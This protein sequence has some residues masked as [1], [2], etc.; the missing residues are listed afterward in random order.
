MNPTPKHIAFKI[1]RALS[2]SP[3]LG[4]P[5]ALFISVFFFDDPN[6]IA[7]ELIIALIFIY[8]YPLILIANMKLSHSLYDKKKT[9]A[10][11]VLLWPIVLFAYLILEVL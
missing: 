1:L 4:W 5:L 9:L 8:T 3:I 10:Y 7:A 11:V 2:L 6:G